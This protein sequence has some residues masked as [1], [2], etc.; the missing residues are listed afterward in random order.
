MLGWEGELVSE[1]ERSDEGKLLEFL[2]VYR[3]L[4][5]LP[6]GLQGE[7]LVDKLLRIG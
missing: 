7:E 5:E 6:L 1:E 3:L 2:E 4:Q